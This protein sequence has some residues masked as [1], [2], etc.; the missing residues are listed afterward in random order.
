MR[1]RPPISVS[2]DMSDE[3]EAR[4]YP[5]VRRAMPPLMLPPVADGHGCI[6]CSAANVPATGAGAPIP[7]TFDDSNVGF[8]LETRRGLRGGG[9]MRFD[10][11]W[12]GF[13]DEPP[14]G[15]GGLK[16]ISGFVSWILGAAAMA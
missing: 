10:S 3:Y 12:P 16:R 8:G 15:R 11:C 2:S 13:G 5:P 6:R 7:I 14:P 4:V 9:G 1:V